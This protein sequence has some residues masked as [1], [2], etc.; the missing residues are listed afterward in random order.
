[1]HTYTLNFEITIFSDF[2]TIYVLRNKKNTQKELYFEV[3]T[4]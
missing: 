2:F 4:R 3:D 1:M